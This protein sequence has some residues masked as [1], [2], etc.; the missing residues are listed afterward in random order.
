[1][2]RKRPV[3][4]CTGNYLLMSTPLMC[5]LLNY[6]LNKPLQHIRAEAK[7]CAHKHT[8]TH[9]TTHTHLFLALHLGE[10]QPCFDAPPP[11]PLLSLFFLSFSS[12]ELIY[13]R[14]RSRHVR[15]PFY[16]FSIPSIPSSVFT[17]CLFQRRRPKHHSEHY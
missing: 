13:V 11:P 15:L 8:R 4:V 5:W 12:W 16:S 10:C 6:A 1:M 9:S 14:F 2:L 17:S 7:Q 3:G